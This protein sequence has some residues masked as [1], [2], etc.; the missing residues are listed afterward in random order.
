MLEKVAFRSMVEKKLTKMVGTHKKILLYTISLVKL[1][2]R[3]MFSEDNKP[4]GYI[5][6]I[7]HYFIGMITLMFLIFKS[8]GEAL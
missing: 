8:S 3:C 1:I 6:H 7:Y 2:M 5:Y 4:K